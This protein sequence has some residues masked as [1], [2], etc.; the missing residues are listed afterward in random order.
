M[1]SLIIG[2]IHLH[3]KPVETFLKHFEQ[4]YDEIVCLGDYFDDWNDSIENTID[5][6]LWLKSIIDNPK[7]V[8]I[9]GNHC[10][11]YRFPNNHEFH[12]YGFTKEKSDAINNILTKEDWKKFKLFH[13]TQGYYCSHAGITRFAFDD[14]LSDE[15]LYKRC[16]EALYNAEINVYDKVLGAGKIRGGEQKVGGI[17]WAHWGL[18]LTPIPNFKQIVGHTQCSSPLSEYFPNKKKSIG[19]NHCIDCAGKYYGVIQDGIFSTIN[20]QN[21]SL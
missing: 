9:N 2:D 19:E 18:E 1:K 20:V 13:K 7:Y 8:M 17:I 10:I 21:I 3:H 6:A 11:S 15:F 5:T 4:D 16:E 14:K 12:Y